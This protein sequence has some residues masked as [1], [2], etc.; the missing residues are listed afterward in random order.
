MGTTKVAQ[1]I[2]A[3][4]DAEPKDVQSRLSGSGYPYF[5]LASSIEVA[6]TII[7]RG[8]GSCEIDQLAAWL[9]YASTK[10]GTFATRM[11]SA[12]YF[13]LLETVG[14]K[15]TITD[16]AKRIIAPVMPDDSINA[17]VSAF[18]SVPLFAKVYEQFRGGPLPPEVGL[19]NLFKQTHKILPDRAATAVKVFMRSAEQA[20]FFTEGRSRL[21]RPTTGHLHLSPASGKAKES[22]PATEQQITPP[23]R[24]RFAGG[25]GGSGGDG[26]VHS[27]LIALLRDLPA[28]G[29]AWDAQ[30]KGKFLAAF[31]AMIEFIYP[32]DDGP[33]KERGQ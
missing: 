33:G 3:K 17:K 19:V 22:A 24:P 9:S 13:S 28:P 31:Q 25:G 5:D 21:I 10:S 12:R 2:N 23:E 18:L 16:L 6:E 14:G 8:G 20:G 26:I 1:T 4:P 15:I 30:K 7:N 32:D 27:A 11:S 29:T